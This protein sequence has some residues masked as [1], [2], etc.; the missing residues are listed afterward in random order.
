MPGDDWVG[1]L[2]RDDTS[3][4]AG[5]GP[6][7]VQAAQAALGCVFPPELADFLRAVDGVYDLDGQWFTG[8]PLDRIV[9]G[10]PC[11]WTTGGPP[12]LIPFGDNGCGAP[13]CVRRDETAAT[14]TVYLWNPVEQEARPLATSLRSFWVGWL[15]GT[16]TT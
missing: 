11:L 6:D 14:C 4:G 5:C 2:S 12:E 16:I 1:L 3:V 8:W 15:D 7:R 10:A 9:T 13:F